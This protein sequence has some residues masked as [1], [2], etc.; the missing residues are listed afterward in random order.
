MKKIS[1]LF[2]AALMVLMLAACGTEKKEAATEEGFSPALDTST[3]CNIT[4]AGGYD[5]F[6]D[7]EAELDSFN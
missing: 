2:L 4:V 1:S 6:E 3:E 5:K 7:I